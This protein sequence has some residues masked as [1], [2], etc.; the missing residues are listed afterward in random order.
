MFWRTRWETLLAP[1]Y[2]WHTC[3]RI[4]TG[5]PCQPCKVRVFARIGF[6][7]ASAGHAFRFPEVEDETIVNELKLLGSSCT[8]LTGAEESVIGQEHH[9]AQ[10][11][12]LTKRFS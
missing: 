8:E 3:R 5:S 7:T 4:A 1:A 12:V 11:K 6:Y 2:Q 9:G 10:S